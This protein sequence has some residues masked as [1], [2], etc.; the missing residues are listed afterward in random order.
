MKVLYKLLVLTFL[1]L[2]TGPVTAEVV[3]KPAPLTWDDV[4]G[5]D[6]EQLYGK[7]CASC[8]G[9]EGKGDGLA[10]QA[11]PQPVPDL[12]HMP[13]DDKGR[14]DHGRI[15]KIIAGRDR[16]VRHDVI[17]MPNWE[18]QFRRVFNGYTVEGRHVFA[19]K[20]IHALADHVE[21]LQAVAFVD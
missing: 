2:F 17:G 18:Q 6:G 14:I 9:T 7:L 20:N 11:L 10:T 8:H 1:I 3:I 16:E 12:T 19:L 15:E 13:R 21:S 4:A 5:Q